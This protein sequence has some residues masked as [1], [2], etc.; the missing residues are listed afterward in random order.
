MN[1]LLVL[2]T[3]DCQENIVA[4]NNS[5]IFTQLF[6]SEGRVWCLGSLFKNV[7][8]EIKALIWLYLL[9]RLK[10]GEGKLLGLESKDYG[11]KL[12]IALTK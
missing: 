3:L 7:K 8:T 12:D 4:S 6:S 11:L 5:F 10:Y 2:Y 9:G 1:A